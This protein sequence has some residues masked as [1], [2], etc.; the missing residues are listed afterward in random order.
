MHTKMF[1][2]N[3]IITV[4]I[5]FL[6]LRT[7]ETGRTRMH[8]VRRALAQRSPGGFLS[9]VIPDLFVRYFAL[10]VFRYTK[11]DRKVAP[12]H[13]SNASREPKA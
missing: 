4:P 6:G 10:I 1:V 3:K 11:S 5:Y 9:A 13:S 8:L 7:G 12:D 2:V